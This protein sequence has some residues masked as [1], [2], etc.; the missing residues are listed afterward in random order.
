MPEDAMQNS[1]KVSINTIAYAASDEIDI[2]YL[3][4]AN[5]GRVAVNADTTGSTQ[6]KSKPVGANYLV[7]MTPVDLAQQ[8]TQARV[9][10]VH[11][12]GQGESIAGQL[13]RQIM[14]VL[15]REAGA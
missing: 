4:S 7:T 14:K 13:A 11:L 2:A 10:I 12:S 6:K 5:G 9:G 15:V 3:S 8:A 1:F